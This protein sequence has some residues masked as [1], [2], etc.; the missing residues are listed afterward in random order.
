MTVLVGLFW[1]IFCEIRLTLMSQAL[2]DTQQN[3]IDYNDLQAKSINQQLITFV[4]FASTTLST[5]GLG[6][7]YPTSNIERLITTFILIL[8]AVLSSYIIQTLIHII[9]SI[10]NQNINQHQSNILMKFFYTLQ[11]F[12]NGEILEPKLT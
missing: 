12:N 6:D 3:F 7:F 2:I 11:R 10:T 5:V 1:A 9:T 4:Y 8:G